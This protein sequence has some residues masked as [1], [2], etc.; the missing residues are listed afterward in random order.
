MLGVRETR[1]EK[2]KIAPKGLRILEEA[3]KISCQE[4]IRLQS[5]VA[6]QR[7]REHRSVP[8]K[9]GSQEL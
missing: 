1:E 5:P 8:G 3:F 7:I 4:T 9:E 6:M 2:G